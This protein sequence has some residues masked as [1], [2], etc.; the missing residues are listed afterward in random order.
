MLIGE[1]A[2]RTGTATSALRYY[3]SIGLL[4]APERHGGRRVYR[5]DALDR[6][7]FIRFA[8]VCGFQLDEIGVLLRVD[9]QQTTL[10]ARLRNLATKKMK[11]VDEL[12]AT[13]QGMKRFL[14]ATLACRC[15]TAEE[16]GRIVRSAG[17]T[18]HS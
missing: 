12:I 15:I 1:L 7:A 2:R 14:E 9:K 17:E 13:A 18:L 10:S 6:I 11:E 4:P 5:E 16:C 3:E 8:Q